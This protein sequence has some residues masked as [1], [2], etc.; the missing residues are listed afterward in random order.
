VSTPGL[1]RDR[2]DPNG[3]N[4]TLVTWVLCWSGNETAAFDLVLPGR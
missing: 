1:G 3:S 4:N 2:V